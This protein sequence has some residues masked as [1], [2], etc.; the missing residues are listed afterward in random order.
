MSKVVNL[1]RRTRSW[2]GYPRS[3]SWWFD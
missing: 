2:V 1:R 3:T